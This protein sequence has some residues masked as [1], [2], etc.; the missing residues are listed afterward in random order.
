MVWVLASTTA[1]CSVRSKLVGKNEATVVLTLRAVTASVAPLTTIIDARTRML[2]F[3]SVRFAC[4]D[5]G[6]EP[7]FS[8]NEDLA[9]GVCTTAFAGGLL[10]VRTWRTIGSRGGDSATV[11]EPERT[12]R[13]RRRPRCADSVARARQAYRAKSVTFGYSSLKRGATQGRHSTHTAHSARRTAAT[14]ERSQSRIG[15]SGLH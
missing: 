5:A 11:S 12:E 14:T 10:P 15:F 1:L 8:S 9:D 7:S 13:S 4:L 3:C 6:V 2:S